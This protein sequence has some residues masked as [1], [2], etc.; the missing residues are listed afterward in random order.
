[1]A[2]H[3][4][5]LSSSDRTRRL[6][7]WLDN[8]N[9]GPDDGIGDDPY[10]GFQLK[11]YL[12][13]NDHFNFENNESTWTQ[14]YLIS[15][16]YFDPKKNNPVMFFTGAEG[17]DITRLYSYA[18]GYARQVAQEL[19]AMIVFME[20]RFFGK[21]FPYNNSTEADQPS[22]GSIGMLT[23]EQA[24]ADYS[25]LVSSILDEYKAWDSP[26]ISFGGSLAGTL[27]A[28]LRIRYPYLID[29]AWASSTPLLGYP[30]LKSQ[31]LWRKQITDNFETLAPGC[32]NI[33]RRGF[34]GIINVSS[35]EFAESLPVC[36]APSS[37]SWQDIQNVAWSLLEGS[38][39]FCYPPSESIIPSICSNMTNGAKNGSKGSAIFV[40]LIKTGGARYFTGKCLNLTLFNEEN[41][42]PGAVGW[43]YL[44]ST[45]IVHPIGANNVTDM[46]PPMNW[47]IE[48]TAYWAQKDFGV[49]PDPLHMPMQF[50]MSHMSRFTRTNSKILFVYG[51]RDPWHTLGVGI[52]SLSP[53]LPVITIE[54]GSHCADQVLPEPRFDTKSMVDARKQVLVQLKTWVEQVRVEKS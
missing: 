35:E 43:N 11:T 28:L 50:G 15:D 20:H 52:K 21:S 14:R 54:E 17:G 30:G 9:I 33:V 37:F 19:G 22:V 6:N 25:I 49:S 53:S 3:H 27:S 38:G 51:L 18:Y 29:M 23:V 16:A 48:D 42:L 31:Y 44:A 10:P 34:A 8:H 47:S 4:Q 41:N 24:L 7:R 45:T 1:M 36:E 5:R 40:E 13:K 46:F 39:E 2:Q 32:P 12:Q 26:T